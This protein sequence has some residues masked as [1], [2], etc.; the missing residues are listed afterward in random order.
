MSPE[1]GLLQ[2]LLP[3]IPEHR[4][5][6]LIYFD[7]TRVSGDHVIGWNPLDFS[8][9]KNLPREAWQ[10]L[11]SEK[12]HSVFNVLSQTFEDL[13]E[14]EK[15]L[16]LEAIYGLVALDQVSLKDMDTLLG[17]GNST[18][19]RAIA[20]SQRVE[21][22][23]RRF[24]Q[25]YDTSATHHT[26]ATALRH[27]LAIFFQDPLARVFASNAVTWRDVL[28]HPRIVFIDLS[29]LGPPARETVAKLLLAEIEVEISRRVSKREKIPYYLYID[30]FADFIQAGASTNELFAKARENG[31]GL[32][33]AHQNRQELQGNLEGVIMGSVKTLIIMQVNA[34][35]APFYTRMLQQESPGSMSPSILQH[36]QPGQ[37]IVGFEVDGVRHNVPVQMPLFR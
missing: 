27:K 14:P 6:D 2:D 20:E 26:A 4:L 28:A 31:L 18:L 21:E 32:T 16:L 15:E 23:T 33:L 35:D 9:G 5:D 7:P 25:D 1:H 24:W 37:A 12:V 10:V 13:A 29:Q 30:E 17:A 11:Y 19:R 3:H 36:L 8:E 22:R 34:Q